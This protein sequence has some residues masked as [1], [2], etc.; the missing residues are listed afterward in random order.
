M[1]IKNVWA[2]DTVSEEQNK[3]N[4]GTM[5]KIQFR[6]ILTGIQL[7]T[8]ADPNNRN[9]HKWVDIIANR[10]QAQVVTNLR[11]IEKRGKTVIDADQRPEVIWRGDKQELLDTI[12][13]LNNKN[14]PGNNFNNLYE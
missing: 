3:V 1:A 4:G 13:E 9:Y 7:P 5:Y 10:N 14:N 2:I 12:T 8:Y 6:N 11:T